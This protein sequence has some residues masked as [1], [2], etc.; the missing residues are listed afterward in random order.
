MKNI[1]DGLFFVF[2]LLW[3][4][5]K[6]FYFYSL[7]GT[8]LEIINSF[9]LVL[10]PK[11]LMDNLMSRKSRMVLIIVMLFCLW[12]FLFSVLKSL[13][14][15]EKSICAEENRLT[16]KVRLQNK[17]FS[18]RHEQLE[19]PEILKQ[20]EFALKCME[21]G[22]AEACIQGIF[23]IISSV[24]V[25]SGVFYI[26]REL[27]LWVWLIIVLVVITNIVGHIIGAKN[28]YAEMQEET[29][30]ERKL[31]YLRGR[32]MNKEYGKEIRSF[33]ICDFIL[34]KTERAIEDFFE[35]NRRYNRKYNR[36]LWWIQVMEG[37]QTF[38]L[39]FYNV[40]L[41]SAQRITVGVF[42]MNISALLQFSNSLNLIFTQLIHIAEQSIYLRDY[43][44]F[45]LMP[46][47]YCGHD[48]VIPKD[49]YTIEFQDVS[50]RYPGQEQYA[51]EHVSVIIRP[52][53]KISIVGAN[54]AGKTTFVKLLLG[55]YRPDSGKILLN[56]ADI[57][58]L[59][60]EEYIRLFA[61]VM[62]DYQLYSFRIIDN[63]VFKEKETKEERD[64]AS[65]VL[66]KMGLKETVDKLPC[67]MDSYL[68]QRYNDKGIELSGGEYQKLAIARALYRNTPIILLDEPTSA[69][70]PQS[71]Y[72]IY[73]S[74]SKITAKKTVLYISHRLASCLLCDRVLVFD[75]GRIIEEGSHAELMEKDGVYAQMFQSQASLYGIS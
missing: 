41:L 25:I 49:K 60:R 13:I 75:K 34:R 8:L 24:I 73:R 32:L 16:M 67:G 3:K 59:E 51:L 42:M 21:K 54:G 1:F 68:T 15:K 17:L 19:D 12:Q 74:F 45:L 37:I 22:E 50:F 43:R 66:V 65:E 4:D 31:Y 10:F 61:A 64:W 6:V 57:E 70:S 63:L 7:F 14:E 30:T 69:L 47:H 20:Y 55:L 2:R 5:K 38:V 40:L 9:I 35:L 27:P 18:L 44:A 71:E 72:H 11:Y 48:S 29:P 53:E 58:R 36:T 33:Q 56:G 62:Q 46:S 52:D 39:Y 28:T 26:L 23:S